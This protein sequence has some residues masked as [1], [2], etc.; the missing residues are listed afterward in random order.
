MILA[1]TILFS[2]IWFPI[3]VSVIFMGFSLYCLY[4]GLKGS[5]GDL[6]LQMLGIMFIM[7]IPL[8]WTLYFSVLYF[9]K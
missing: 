1:L 8:M 3:V 7:G 4:E 5:Y 9:L 2:S 6:F